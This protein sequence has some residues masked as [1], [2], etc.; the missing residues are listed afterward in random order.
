MT[1][2]SGSFL[3][4]ASIMTHFD[5]RRLEAILRDQQ[6]DLGHWKETRICD[7]A[8][9]REIDLESPQAQVVTGVRRS[10]KSTL[11][12]LALE[13]AALRYGYVNF[14]DEQLAGLESG[15]LNDLLEVLYKIYGDFEHLFLDE[16]QN[17]DGWHLFVNRLLR[18]GLRVIITGSNAKLLSSDLATHL[19]GRCREIMLLPFS[20]ANFCAAKA[21]NTDAKSTKSRAFLRAAF[22][23]YLSG[24][25]FP[26]TLRVADSRSYVQTLVKNILQRDIEQR[27]A[28]S[29]R[30][31]FEALA[32]HLLNVCP[33]ANSSAVLAET[34]QVK[35]LQTVRN[36]VE[37][38]KEAFLLV[39][40]K[41][42]SAKSKVRLTG[43]KLYAVDVALM[44]NRPDAFAGENLGWRLETVV[45]LELVRR[46][47]PMGL[48]LYY[49]A[50]RYSECDFVVNQGRR[51]QQV[52][53]VCY[54]ISAEK[55]KKRELRGLVRAAKATGCR[56]LLLLTDHES[57]VQT[58]DGYEIVIQ[59]VFEWVCM[60]S[61]KPDRA[62]S[63]LQNKALS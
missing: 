56:D 61:P 44:N 21:V 38:L 33:A 62:A 53:Q 17:V 57:G 43:E 29:Y 45:F 54:D 25:G 50:D 9:A 31:A 49:F 55:T 60:G 10:G 32:N 34:F 18:K 15:D 20:F 7:R 63:A 52:I 46:T 41:K 2:D 14:D 4:M 37:Y 35:S 28:V 1:L 11:C 42:Y 19:T 27:F 59:P 8:E 16:I 58:L 30:A 24:G 5:K 47:R 22:D 48:D 3:R 26:E 36:Y 40:L 6:E 23:E 39:G 12:L 51:T 13:K